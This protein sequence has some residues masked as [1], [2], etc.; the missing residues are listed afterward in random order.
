MAFTADDIEAGDVLLFRGTS[1]VSW[2][3]RLFDGTEVNHAAVALGGG[4]LAEAGG[5]GLQ[6]RPVP[7]AFG[8]G[9]LLRVH[10]LP[11]DTDTAPV[12]AKAN[13]YLGQ[14]P[15]YAYQQIVLLAV[16]ALTRKLPVPRV[17]RRFVRSAVDHAA[18]AL[19][20]LLPVGS[21][22]MICSEYVYRCYHEAVEGDPNAYRLQVAG[23]DFAAA[24]A[25][26]SL[27][28][29]GLDN[30]QDVSINVSP[31]FSV[32]V[33]DP[34]RAAALVEADLAPAVVELARALLEEGLA[35]PEDL[36]PMLVDQSFGGPGMQPPE[37]TDEEMLASMGR[38]GAALSLRQGIGA[39]VQSSF[40]GI[41]AT[42]TAAALKGA[43]EGIRAVAVHPDFVTP[44]DLLRSRSLE[45]VGRYPE[46]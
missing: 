14:A 11:G 42:I 35:S 40:G 17:A 19:M 21:K 41:G 26:G 8:R 43:L 3:I 45:L 10:R 12:V 4:Q 32:P 1:F 29:W 9:E 44:G 16:L 23:V 39:P 18:A 5:M 25:G 36:P 22:W 31:S 30:I 15:F 37:P 38:F 24:S 20:N 7:S 13:E 34:L 2:A 46:D 28:D 27:L 6:Q 33:G